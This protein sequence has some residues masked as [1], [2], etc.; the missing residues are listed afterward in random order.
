MRRSAGVS[1]RERPVDVPMTTPMFRGNG[2]VTVDNARRCQAEIA[3]RKYIQE[4]GGGGR[5][6]RWRTGGLCYRF[7]LAALAGRERLPQSGRKFCPSHASP[8]LSHSFWIHSQLFP[9]VRERERLDGLHVP[10]ACVRVQPGRMYIYYV[11]AM[12]LIVG[13]LGRRWAPTM[14]TWR[15]APSA[16]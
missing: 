9:V 7:G 1:R 3:D 13:Q 4:G 6:A 11:I 15:P 5:S 16:C 14:A 12:M 10:P 2:T 8:P